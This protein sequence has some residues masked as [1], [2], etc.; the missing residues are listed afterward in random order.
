MNKEFL[1]NIVNSV[2][3]KYEINPVIFQKFVQHIEQLPEY[4]ENTNTALIE[5]EKRKNKLETGSDLFIQRFLQ[6]YKYLLINH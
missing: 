5:R 2:F 1:N 3:D 4:F 6:K